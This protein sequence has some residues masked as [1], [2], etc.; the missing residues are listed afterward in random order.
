MLNHVIDTVDIG[1]EKTQIG[2]M[3]YASYTYFEINFNT[4]KVILL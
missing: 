4:Y 2:V 1:N 3:Q